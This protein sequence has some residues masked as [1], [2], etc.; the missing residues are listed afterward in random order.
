[1]LLFQFLFRSIHGF[2]SSGVL[3]SGIGW[4]WSAPGFA[5]VF[6]RELDRKLFGIL[7]PQA[8]PHSLQGERGHLVEKW[9]RQ[10]REFTFVKQGDYKETDLGVK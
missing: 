3:G 7:F 8:R 10:S 6:L 4:R 1:M 2:I 5:A 9:S